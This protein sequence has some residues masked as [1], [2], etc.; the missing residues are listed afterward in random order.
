MLYGRMV[1]TKFNFIHEYKI[2][3]A[4]LWPESAKVAS[5]M[6]CFECSFIAWHRCFAF[7]FALQQGYVRTALGKIQL[8]DH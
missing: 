3:K 7:Y 5:F 8:Q 4:H 1:V 6:G 2:G